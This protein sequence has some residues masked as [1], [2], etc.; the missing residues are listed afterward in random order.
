MQ[1]KEFNFSEPHKL[2]KVAF[3]M[4]IG[5]I[6]KQ[7]LP[8]LLF[9]VGGKLLRNKENSD[10]QGAKVFY[11]FLGAYFIFLVTHIR[12]FLQYLRFRF[13]IQNGELIEESGIF[14]KS[15]TSIPL[16]RIQ[17]VNLIQ[18]YVHRI[19]HTCEL[20]IETAGSDKTEFLL[21]AIDREKALAF[22][23]VLQ[24]NET[25]EGKSP[26]QVNS[27]VFQIGIAGMFKLFISE[28][29]LKTLGLI[30]LFV[31]ARIDDLRQILGIDAEDYLEKEFSRFVLTM[32]LFLP[33]ALFILIITFM[34]SLVRV[35]VRYHNMELSVTANGFNMQWGFF[36]TQQKNIQQNKV[37]LVGWNQNFLRKILGIHILRFYMAGEDVTKE[38]VRI[39]L[40][41]MHGKL[42]HQ[43]IYPY[44]SIWP[45]NVEEL[46]TI[47]PSYGWRKTIIYGV[48]LF[49]GLFVGLY[50][51]EPVYIILPSIMFAYF[52][53]H[54]FVAQR[55][56]HFWFN[57][58]TLQV[59]KG[60]WG[61]EM[62][63]LNFKNVQHVVVKTGPYLRSKK[64]ATVIFHS[65]G[66]KIHIPFVSVDLAQYLADLCLVNIQFKKNE[67]PGVGS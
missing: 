44:Q 51:F 16:H 30:L 15:K 43:L 19:T 12:Q 58:N 49:V 46:K 45:G 36:Q 60:V 18:N 6:T 27:S 34:V 38:S 59:R 66:D 32:K 56:F 53:G 57:N 62:L 28:N 67:S 1:T 39:Q 29:H 33:I 55:N 13:Y 2:S 54:N 22:Q 7:S 14:S 4:L 41:V 25:I 64:L 63:L 48:P 24:R 17:S 9:I 50:F 5:K 31:V 65:A 8:I 11:Y 37:Q 20:K 23:N 61:R 40:P 10:W 21:K 26:V 47:H 3:L 35:L 52:A 42:L